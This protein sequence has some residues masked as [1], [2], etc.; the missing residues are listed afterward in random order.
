MVPRCGIGFGLGL[1][2][3]HREDVLLRAVQV[4]VAGAVRVAPLDAD[5]RGLHAPDELQ[6]NFQALLHVLEVLDE[7]QA[8]GSQRV[9]VDAAV[10]LGLEDKAGVLA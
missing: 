10:L 8:P 2:E 3:E 1:V 7:F 4:L 6:Y 9:S 5:A